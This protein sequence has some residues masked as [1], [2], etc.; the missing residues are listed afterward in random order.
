MFSFSPSVGVW[1]S[2]STACLRD[3]LFRAWCW[4]GLTTDQMVSSSDISMFNTQPVSSHLPVVCRPADIVIITFDSNNY[5]SLDQG[6][7]L[8]KLDTFLYT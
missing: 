6:P 4:S 7:T 1:Q 2:D 5:T 3:W 8:S